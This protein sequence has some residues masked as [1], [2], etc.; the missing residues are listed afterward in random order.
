MIKKLS[1]IFTN[2]GNELKNRENEFDII[3]DILIEMLE[4]ITSD[5]NILSKIFIIEID[6]LNKIID[7]LLKKIVEAENRLEMFKKPAINFRNIDVEVSSVLK[8][9]DHIN[10]KNDKLKD[11]CEHFLKRFN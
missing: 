4:Y 3:I 7:K 9:I 6:K 2:L 11:K 10:N 1:S 8:A 5:N